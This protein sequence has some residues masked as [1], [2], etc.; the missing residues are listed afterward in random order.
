MNKKEYSAQREL[1]I[2]EAEGLL[3]DGDTEGYKAKEKE[4]KVLD[5]EFEAYIANQANLNALKDS[6][7]IGKAAQGIIDTSNKAVVDTT[8]H[9]VEEDMYNSNEYRN[10]FKNFIQTGKKIE[11]FQNADTFTG[12]S[13]ASA[14][15]PTTIIEKIIE[16]MESHGQLYSRVTKLN[17]KGGVEIPILSL[18]PEATWIG[19]GSSSDRKKVDANTKV[20]FN[21]YGLECKIAISLLASITTL[22]MFETKLIK[23]VVK[24]IIKALDKGIIKGTGEGQMEGMTICSRVPAANI[25]TIAA[26]DFTTWSGWKK[27]FF[28]KIPLAYK[29]E[30]DFIMASGTFEGYIDGM[31]DANGNPVARSNY[32]IDK[33]SQA[34]FGGHDVIQVEDDVIEPYDTASVGDIVAIFCRLSDYGINSNLGMTIEKYKDHDLN[35]IINKAIMIVDGKLIDANGVMF[36]KKGA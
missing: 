34:R 25:I 6:V 2:N 11:G 12:T 29:A 27:K 9:P 33:K 14:V 8:V 16:K 24:A 3:N 26:A 10:A 4:I 32:G 21:Y 13:D 36:I 28:A 15:I 20:V 7:V 18:V 1:L 35:Q 17:I 5:K 30:G 22:Q 31:V 19:E 23:L